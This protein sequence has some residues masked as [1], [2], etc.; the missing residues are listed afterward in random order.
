MYT[1]ASTK[2]VCVTTASSSLVIEDGARADEL[3]AAVLVRRLDSVTV[4][5][6]ST[7]VTIP[8]PLL[9]L[10]VGIKIWEPS[11]VV[12]KVVDTMDVVATD[13]TAEFDVSPARLELDVSPARL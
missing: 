2:T 1:T 7:G 6:T 9:P 12:A 13:E 3:G 4:G 11:V 8:V 10:E 5:V